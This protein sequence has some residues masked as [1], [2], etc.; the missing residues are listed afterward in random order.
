MFQKNKE[1]QKIDTD[2]R[3]MVEYAQDRIKRKKNLFRHFIIFVAG[4]IAKI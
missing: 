4:G 1:S 2:Q 3:R